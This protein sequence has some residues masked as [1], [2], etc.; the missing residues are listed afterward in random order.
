MVG[1]VWPRHRHRGRPLNSVVRQP[2]IDWKRLLESKENAVAFEPK[3]MVRELEAYGEGDVAA[4]L[5]QLGPK[6]IHRIGVR[7]HEIYSDFDGERGPM[8]DTAICLAIV[9]HIEGKPRP[10]KR[11]KRVYPKTSK[12]KK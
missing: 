11:K 10:L 1:R 5:K 7:A 9:E 2:M 4:K 12:A 6:D 8:L 3:D